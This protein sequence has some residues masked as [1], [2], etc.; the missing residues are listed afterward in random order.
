M[1]QTKVHLLFLWPLKD[2]FLTICFRSL[3]YHIETR[4]TDSSH[5]IFLFFK[6]NILVPLFYIHIL[7]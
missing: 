7:E 1:R 4:E 6:I 3:D 2:H 5:F